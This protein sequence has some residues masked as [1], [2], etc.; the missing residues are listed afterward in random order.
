MNFTHQQPSSEESLNKAASAIRSSQVL[1]IP[2]TGRVQKFCEWIINQRNALLLNGGALE[3]L[4]L[5]VAVFCFGV[6]V[7]TLVI[8]HQK[9]LPQWPLDIT[10]NS[11]LSVF[12]QISQWSLAVPITEC[13]GQLKFLWAKKERRLLTDFVA[14]QEATK[15]P[16][17]SVVL[18]KRLRMR[19]VIILHLHNMIHL[20]F[21]Q[22]T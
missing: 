11:L 4:S 7:I 10:I 12:S 22:D 6:I 2:G 18:L 16:W 19:F 3:I 13:I 1:E 17:Q 9:P 21:F 15:G 20:L 5:I 14:F 8:H